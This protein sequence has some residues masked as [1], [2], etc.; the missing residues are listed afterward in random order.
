MTVKEP[1]IN[2]YYID[3]I[4][5]IDDMKLTTSKKQNLKKRAGS[6]IV[7]LISENGILTA[8]RN[9]ILGLNIPNYD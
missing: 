2:E 1:S 7:E 4:M 9:I 3:D 6:G 5:F 8:K